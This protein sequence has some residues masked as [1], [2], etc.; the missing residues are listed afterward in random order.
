MLTL[1]TLETS[2]GLDKKV[3]LNYYSRMRFTN[4][5]LPLLR[6]AST[7]QPPFARI[8][9]VLGAGHEAALD[10]SD[11]SLRRPGSYSLRAAANHAI[12]MTSLT[13]DRLASETANKNITFIHS[14]PGGVDTNAARSLGPIMQKALTVGMFLLK[15]I[16]LVKGV[17]ESGERHLWAATSDGFASGL[18]LLG[19]NGDRVPSKVLEQLRKEGVGEKVWVHTDGVFGKINGEG[20]KYEG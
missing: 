19:P 6:T 2:E 20:V 1:G 13:F 15:P 5:L 12:S 14:N 10:I 16:G 4:N 8:I 9:S 18:A 3:S 17:G 11:L 7:S